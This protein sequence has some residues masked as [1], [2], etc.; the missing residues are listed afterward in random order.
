MRYFGQD[1]S[2]VSAAG[3][4]AIYRGGLVAHPD[5]HDTWSSNMLAYLFVLRGS[6]MLRYIETHP[7][8][9]ISSMAGGKQAFRTF[10]HRMEML[11]NSVCCG[12]SMRRCICASWTKC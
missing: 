10:L 6:M 1:R 3:D 4:G 12:A 8:T 11:E 9:R 2:T 5:S 7:G